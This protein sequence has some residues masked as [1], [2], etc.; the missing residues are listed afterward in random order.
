MT[1]TYSRVQLL[2]DFEAEKDALELA[3]AEKM[4]TRESE[5]REQSRAQLAEQ[6]VRQSPSYSRTSSPLLSEG[7]RADNIPSLQ[8]V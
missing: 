2:E 5:L 1:L 4:S 8:A 3:A 7:C 6:K